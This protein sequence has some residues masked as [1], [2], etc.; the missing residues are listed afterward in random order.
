[1]S[2]FLIQ[3]SL[4]FNLCFVCYLHPHSVS[5]SILH[6]PRHNER[7]NGPLP[8][9]SKLIMNSR[10]NQ[11]APFLPSLKWEKWEG[12]GMRGGMNFRSNWP[13]L[14]KEKWNPLPPNQLWIPAQTKNAPFLPS[15]KRKGNEA[16]GRGGGRGVHNPVFGLIEVVT[17]LPSV[18]YLPETLETVCIWARFR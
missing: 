13:T 7:R 1:M 12:G 4:L 5:S 17:I 9:L 2:H 18:P 6:N 3:V 15:L 8:L 10:S 14:N 11:I 16:E